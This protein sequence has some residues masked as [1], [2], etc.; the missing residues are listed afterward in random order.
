MMDQGRGL[1]PVPLTWFYLLLLDFGYRLLLF[2]L[3]QG[4]VCH[5][6]R[7]NLKCLVCLLSFFGGVKD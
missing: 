5:G 3:R 2:L 4:L 1:T 6:A 7:A